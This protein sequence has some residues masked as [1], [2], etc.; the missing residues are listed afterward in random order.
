MAALEV[1]ERP[2]WYAE[3]VA[4]L[5]IGQGPS[6]NEPVVL[7]ALLA[8]IFLNSVN[9]SMHGQDKFVK[10]VEK[11]HRKINS[12]KLTIEEGWFSEVDMEIILKWPEQLGGHTSL[13]SLSCMV[14]I[15]SLTLG[16]Q[17]C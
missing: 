8:L 11:V 1:E 2:K 9:E 7:L 12:S 13:Q 6:N 15:M 14:M 10:T 17:C 3:A 5:W 4:R 16:A